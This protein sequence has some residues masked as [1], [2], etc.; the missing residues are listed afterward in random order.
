MEN[1]LLF[2]GFVFGVK[3]EEAT[4]NG[5]LE[6]EPGQRRA[7]VS[8]TRLGFH[9]RRE[10]SQW[11]SDQG[12]SQRGRGRLSPV[13][14]LSGPAIGQADTDGDTFSL[15]EPPANKGLLGQLPAA[16]LQRTPLEG[17]GEGPQGFR[18]LF[19][20]ALAPGPLR[21]HRLRPFDS[22]NINCWGSHLPDGE[23]SPRESQRLVLLT[24]G[25]RHQ[26]GSAVSW[27]GLRR[28][29]F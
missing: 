9:L 6:K 18:L 29:R 5:V 8:S 21:S 17:Q 27:C 20:E 11:G 22:E 28:E 25:P 12:W 19:M 16:L 23:Q 24:P 3:V 2:S 1:L 14:T 4:E 15:P 13:P 26:P 7:S 10:C